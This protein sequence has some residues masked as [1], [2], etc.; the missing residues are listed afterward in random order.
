MTNPTHLMHLKR[1]IE[2]WNRWRK[3]NPNIE[4]DLNETYLPAACLSAVDLSHSHLR[5]SD[6]YAA[7]LWCSDLSYAEANEVNL[8]SANL[9]EANLSQSNLT[10]AEL[11]GANLSRANLS[12][13]NCRRANFSMS[14]LSGAN[15][16]ETDFTDA[17]LKGANLTHTALNLANLKGANL[18]GIMVTDAD[19]SMIMT[20]K[21]ITCDHIYVLSY[22][23]VEGHSLPSEDKYIARFRQALTQFQNVVSDKDHGAEDQTRCAVLNPPETA[24]WP[25]MSVQAVERQENGA[26]IVRVKLSVLAVAPTTA[27]FSKPNYQQLMNNLGRG[28]YYRHQLQIKEE[29]IETYRRQNTDLL[30]VLKSMTRQNVYVQSVSVM[31]NSLMSGVSKY[32]FRGANVGSF[33]ENVQAGGQQQSVQYN[34]A[35]LPSA[36]GGD[37]SVEVEKIFRQL[38]RQAAQV[39]AHQRSQVVAKVIQKKATANPEFKARFLKAL[40]SGSEEL[41]R[42]FSQ[43][44]YISIPMALAKGWLSAA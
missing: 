38:A 2:S 30:E 9:S 6:L 24:S 22:I 19:I 29:Q 34:Q 10:S 15:L 17:N 43:N 12:H 5:Q 32:D 25:E 20:L 44:P 8:S 7:D 3:E 40:E 31:E 36:L 16:S 1:S 42:V 13:A 14:N 11:T 4:P 27:P 41:I 39:P 18:T 37:V 28:D 26:F 23:G 33:A 35:Q 21:S